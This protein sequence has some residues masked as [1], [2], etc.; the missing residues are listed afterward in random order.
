MITRHVLPIIVLSTA[1][2]CFAE[3]PEKPIRIVVPFPPAGGVDIPARA[4]APPL[5]E[6]LRQSVIV[7]NRAGAGGTVGAA[8]VAKSPPD[9]YTLLLGSSSTLTVAPSLYTNLTY[10]PVRDFA[11]I[12]MVEQKCYALVANPGLPVRNVKE[13]VAL[14][15]QHPGRITIA[16]SGVGSSNHLV[17]EL[18]QMKTST[19]FTHVPYKGSAQAMVELIGGQVDLHV[20][21]VM[22]ALPH[23]RS[24]KV[25]A[26]GV[27]TRKHRAAQLPDVPTLDEAGVTGFEAMGFTA[28]IAPAGTPHEILAKLNSAMHK[29]LGTPSVRDYIRDLGSDV[30]PGTPESLAQYIREDLARWKQVVKEG[31]IKVE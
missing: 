17:G 27:T 24:G 12:T 3:Y 18:I 29:V 25:R 26:L 5:G 31:G 22:S 7:E 11:P 23:I 1:A 8:S 9:G 13:L 20:D 6:L 21:Q 19:R 15:K 2:S 14:A 10:D 28:V 16:S 4:F 30:V